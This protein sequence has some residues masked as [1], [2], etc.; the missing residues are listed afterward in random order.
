MDEQAATVRQTRCRSA[1]AVAKILP[2]DAASVCILVV[3]TFLLLASGWLHSPTYDEVGHFAAGLEHWTIGTYTMYRVDPPLVRMVATLP[4]L[5][6][7]IKGIQLLKPVGDLDREEVPVGADLIY[8][9]RASVR[10]FFAIARWACIPFS[11]LGACT[12]WK[13][14]MELFGQGAGRLALFLWCFSPNILAWSAL[15][16]PDIGA[17]SFGVAAFF[18]FRRWLHRPANKSAI[19]VGLM[20]GLAELT[21]T[22]WLVLF[23]L[24]AI[25]W[26]SHRV[27]DRRRVHFWLSESKQLGLQF[28]LALFVLN[29]GYRFEGTGRQLGSF[30]FRSN[31]L[32]GITSAPFE[33][34]PSA[35]RFRGTLLESVPVLLPANY[36]QGLD[37]IK[38][39]FETKQSSFLRG[40]TKVGG[41]W[42]YY[43]YALLIK[44][45]LG[46]WVLLAI[47][48][49]QFRSGK[50]ANRL[51]ELILI[52]P[53][54]TILLLV[55]SQTG[56]NHHLRYVAL[57]F[58]FAFIW[59]SR[60]AFAFHSNGFIIRGL[61]A[62]AL[63]WI[64]FSSLWY[65][66]H[67][68]SYF[69]ELV[70]GPAE[71][72][73]HLIS[74]NVDWGQ[75]G[76]LL[77][78]WVKTHPDARPL[79]VD[80]NTPYRLS[81]LAGND[82]GLQDLKELTEP[83]GDMGRGQPSNGWYAIG[84]TCLHMNPSLK[85]FIAH[86][87]I[88][89]IGYSINIYHVKDGGFEDGP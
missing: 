25:I 73:W 44:V 9:N 30:N 70:G 36:L 3:H 19:V 12:C 13:W 60:A 37:F 14:S 34:M 85:P 22:T 39:E 33:F 59:I 16:T 63:S 50:V 51:D 11:W 76:Y 18:C 80:L 71:G 81:V 78:D 55:S 54:L 6:C 64:I 88:Y 48:I 69:N 7:D 42:Y 87:P 52:T 72:H 17:T 68:L 10:L 15:I 46:V 56:F 31:L 75:D 45:P 82:N 4:L 23:P 5:A 21:K 79:F 89:R 65:Y 28:F 57:I 32:S 66:P 29:L 1:C 24:F 26:L 38:W 40:E 67:E 8:S 53:V 77:M 47:A 86:E 49:Y 61:T 74:S 58:P 41:W 2:T 20:T 83:P 84:V 43:I 35:N 62:G 27:L